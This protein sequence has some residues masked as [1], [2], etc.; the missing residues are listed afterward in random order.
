[1]SAALEARE[2]DVA[3][4]I[5]QPAH[6]GIDSESLFQERFVAHHRGRLDTGE[7]AASKGR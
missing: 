3:I 6:S 5:L 7:S 2:I 4:G 1:M